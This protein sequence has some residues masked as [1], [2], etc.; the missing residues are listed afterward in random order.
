[1]ISKLQTHFPHELGI[2]RSSFGTTN[3][4]MPGVSLDQTFSQF[5]KAG[6]QKSGCVSYSPKMADIP[7]TAVRLCVYL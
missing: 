2:H 5:P 1:M 3:G 6:S 7:M 4:A